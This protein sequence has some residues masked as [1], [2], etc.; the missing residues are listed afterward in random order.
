MMFRSDFTGEASQLNRRLNGSV[1]VKALGNK[2]LPVI[3]RRMGNF[4]F[5][6][7]VRHISRHLKFREWL[8]SYDVGKE[9]NRCAETTQSYTLPCLQLVLLE[10]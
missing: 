1:S 9:L 5:I 10:T 7:T 6:D 8:F 3:N 4:Y 2:N